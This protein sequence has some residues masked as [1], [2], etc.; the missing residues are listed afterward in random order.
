MLIFFKIFCIYVHQKIFDFVIMYH[1]TLLSW[2][3][4]LSGSGVRNSFGPHGLQSTRLLCPWGFSR[5]AS[6]SGLS[7]PPP[8]DLPNPGIEPRSPALQA[9]SLQTEPLG[10]PYYVILV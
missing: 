8:G 2:N 3:A 1:V 7:G 4:M 10:K 5:Q 9:N 6:W